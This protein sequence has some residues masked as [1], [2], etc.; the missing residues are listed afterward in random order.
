MSKT[1]T[2]GYRK[3]QKAKTT[4]TTTTTSQQSSFTCYLGG[5]VKKQMNYSREAINSKWIN[6][7]LVTT[8]HPSTMLSTINAIPT[9]NN[10]N[11]GISLSSSLCL[12]LSERCIITPTTINHLSTINE[13]WYIPPPPICST[14]CL[15]ASCC[16]TCCY[17]MA[18]ILCS[19]WEKDTLLGVDRCYRCRKI[20]S[21]VWML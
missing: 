15:L 1:T 13:Q 9:T 5:G 7:R 4:T 16:S 14:E 17:C 19:V 11:D 2:I 18:R 10:T 20:F 21:S 3:P 8:N 12:S 6:R